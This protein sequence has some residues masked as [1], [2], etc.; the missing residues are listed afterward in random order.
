M[1]GK[2]LPID[3]G[4]PVRIVVPGVA[5]A[6]SVKWLD[7]ITVQGEES[8]NHYQRRDYKILPPEAADKEIAKEYWD[9]V[10]AIQDMPV[11]SVI[12][13]PQTG[14]KIILEGDG[15]VEVKGYALPQGSDG[16]VIRVEVS[17]DKGNS[18]QEAELS[19]DELRGRWSWSLW[20]AV[21]AI[22][23]GKERTILSRAIDK[24]GNTQEEYP[25]W[26]LRGVG[27]NGYGESRD[28]TV[29]FA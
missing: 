18:W 7:R 3:H 20:R 29:E 8:H 28:L 14:E 23:P 25:V 24:G 12:A 5:G 2:P 22:R 1:N 15:T 27:Y 21:V 4:A 9:K 26:N 17:V 11:N 16:P 10:P 6:R 13:S 19:N